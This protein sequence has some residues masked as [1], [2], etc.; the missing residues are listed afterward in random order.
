MEES[1]ERWWVSLESLRGDFRLRHSG[2]LDSRESQSIDILSYRIK[3]NQ[4]WDPHSVLVQTGPRWRTTAL[5]SAYCTGMCR[6]NGKYS[7]HQ[8]AV[9][10]VM[11]LPFHRLN[12]F[13]FVCFSQFLFS[14]I[15]VH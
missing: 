7:A 15:S 3:V 11:I 9:I 8:V 2:G 10:P 14:L 5:V 12:A 6:S 4:K 1:R 13:V